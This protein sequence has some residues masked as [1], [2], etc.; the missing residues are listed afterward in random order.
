MKQYI[1]LELVKD[2]SGITVTE[3]QGNS[4]I[5]HVFDESEDAR[6]AFVAL[7]VEF[8]NTE[9]ENGAKYK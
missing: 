5:M 1:R 8:M 2:S 6:K 3:T 9:V 7:L 4:G